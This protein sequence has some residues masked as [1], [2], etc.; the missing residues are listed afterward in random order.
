MKLQEINIRD[1]FIMPYLNRY[2]LYGTRSETAWGKADGF[3]CYSSE[4]LEDWDGPFEIFKRPTGF[5]ADRS[6]WAPECY[7]VNNQFYLITTLG[8]AN[9]KKAVYVLTADQPTGPFSLCSEEALTPT[10]WSAID[11]ALYFENNR[12]YLLFSHTFEDNPDGQMCAVRLTQ[13]LK[14]AMGRPFELFNARQAPWANP[15]PFAQ[16][17]FGLDGDVFFTD[18]P[19]AYRDQNGQLFMIWSSWV[20]GGYGLGLAVSDNGSIRGNWQH[21]REPIFSEN[22]GHGMAFKTFDSTWQYILHQPND[23]GLE[24]PVLYDLLETGDAIVLRRKPA[25]Q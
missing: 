18:G 23:P 4:N 22:G 11:G 7:A 2:Y 16:A 15:V 13:D 19:F 3:D 20:S 1:P 14:R 12:A 21:C 10:D 5:W 9:R 6:Y 17:E 8:A 24:R 25:G